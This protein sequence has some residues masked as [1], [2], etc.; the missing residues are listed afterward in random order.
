V[1]VH[2]QERFRVLCTQCTATYTASAVPIL[3]ALCPACQRRAES[4]DHV[5]AAK[6]TLF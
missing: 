3:T 4:K 5:I 1:N 6:E 2:H